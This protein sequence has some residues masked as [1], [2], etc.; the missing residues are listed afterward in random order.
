MMSDG[1]N[2]LP[3][4]AT[5]GQAFRERGMAARVRWRNEQAR[6]HLLT[7]RCGISSWRHMA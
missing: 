2:I 1:M 4:M 3:D 5:G 7:Q 6:R